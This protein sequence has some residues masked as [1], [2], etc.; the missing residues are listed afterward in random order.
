MYSAA[1]NIFG[2]MV[3]LF[4]LTASEDRLVEDIVYF[5]ASLD[6]PVNSEGN[7]PSESE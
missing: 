5:Y 6:I 3:K 2:G 4:T 7:T 1:A